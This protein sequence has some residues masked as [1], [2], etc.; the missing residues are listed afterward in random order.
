MTRA[1]SRKLRN[2]WQGVLLG[3]ADPVSSP[4]Y[5]FSSV[6]LAAAAAGAGQAVFGVSAWLAALVLVAAVVIYAL[7][8]R[9]VHGGRGARALS[10][11]EFGGWAIKVNGAV[12]AVMAAAALLVSLSAAASLAGDLAPALRTPLLWRITGQDLLAAGLALALAWGVTNRPR[13][14]VRSY[15]P[16]TLGLLLVLWGMTLAAVLTGRAHLPQLDASALAS[17]PLRA[18]ALASFAS[19]L[20]LLTGFDLFASLEIAFEGLEPQRSRK[21]LISLLLAAGTS[22]AFLLL[23]GPAMVALL[24]PTDPASVIYQGM[25]GL[26]PAPLSA[27][28]ALLSM[29]ALLV[30]AAAALLGLQSLVLGLRDRRYAPAFLGQR[31]RA[32]VADRPVRLAA[33]LAVVCF[34]LLGARPGLYLPVYVAGAL[35]LLAVA[36]AAALRRSLRLQRDGSV[37]LVVALLAGLATAVVLLAAGLATLLG[38]AS[39]AWIYLLAVPL[40]YAIFHFTRRRMGSPDP[41]LE[42][43]GQRQQAMFNLGLPTGG[44]SLRARL[45]APALVAAEG[46]PARGHAERWAGEPALVRQVAVA[47]DGSSFAEAALPAAEAAARLFDAT[48]VLLSVLPARGAM[49]ILP[50]GR[51]A[52]NPVEA[53][54]VETEAYLSRLAEKLRAGGIRTSY[55]LA[56]GPVAP[57]IDTMVRELDADL[58]VMSTHG[59]SGVGRFML[60]S[61]ASAAVQLASRPILLLRPG[62]EDEAAPAIQRVLVPLDGSGFAERVLPWLQALAAVVDCEFLLLSVPEVPEPAMYGAMGEAV[63]DLRERAAANSQRYLDQLAGQLSQLGLRVQTVVGGSRPATAILEMAETGDVDLIMLATHGRGGLDRLV[64]GSVAD[65][66]VHHSRCPLFLLPVHE[67]RGASDPVDGG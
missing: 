46:T 6:L 20:G 36:G 65:R 39:G 57:A 9:W 64:M 34:I 30:V 67:R 60:G 28:A 54:Q 55:Y 14:L 1:E 12:E 27:A 8:I 33:A 53:G 31:N 37:W 23:T 16:A 44:D 62:A 19:L 17:P 18:A 43:V 58:L 48:L 38:L 61:N 59:R 25:A 10:E 42:E 66:V 22:L 3:G 13:L 52:G 51:S 47:L 4:L 32:D 50:K 7:V 21:A 29:L 41:L 49:R 24:D 45:P 35:I 11:E 40:L 15:G 5:A 2:P 63:D 56:A 26:L